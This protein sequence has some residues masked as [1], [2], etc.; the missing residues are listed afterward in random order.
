MSGALKGAMLLLLVALAGCTSGPRFASVAATLPPIPPGEARIFIYRVVEPYETQATAEAY[1][2]GRP[3]A[4]TEPGTVLYR[5]VPPGVDTISLESGRPTS[6]QSQRVTLKP[7]EEAYIR[8]G[9]LS[10]VSACGGLTRGQSGGGSNG[11]ADAF[12][13]QVIDQ[14]RALVEMRS[15]PLIPG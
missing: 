5:D 8:L 14:E 3:T 9:T 1:L 13:L 7:G 15:L 4:L 6:D 2:N 10:N 12:Y 11:C